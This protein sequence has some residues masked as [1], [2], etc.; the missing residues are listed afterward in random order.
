LKDYTT[1][2]KDWQKYFEKL[3][4]KIFGKVFFQKEIV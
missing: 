2:S 3:D 1:L 4:A